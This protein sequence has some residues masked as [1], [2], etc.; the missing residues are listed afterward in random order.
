LTFNEYA[1]IRPEGRRTGNDH[2][3]RKFGVGT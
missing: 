1:T 2:G 3:F